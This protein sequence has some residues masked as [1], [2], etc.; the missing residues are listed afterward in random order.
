MAT[1][2]RGAPAVVIGKSA[3]ARIARGTT[4]GAGD[5]TV[6][7]IG[8]AHMTAVHLQVQRLGQADGVTDTAGFRL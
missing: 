8:V 6:I 3:N 5:A 4:S 7:S 1:H 2:A